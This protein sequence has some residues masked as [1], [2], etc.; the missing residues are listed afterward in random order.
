MDKTQVRNVIIIISALTIFFIGITAGYYLNNQSGNKAD[1]DGLEVH[2]PGELTSPLLTCDT[3]VN[4]GS[5][6]FSV[7]ESKLRNKIADIISSGRAT[8]IAVYFRHLMDG[9]WF[10][11]NERENYTPA[12]MLKVPVMITIYKQAETNPDILNKKLKYEKVYVEENPHY[13][14]PDKL[15]IG[16]E[17][18]VDDLVSRMVK[19]S[20]NE[21]MYL[22]RA[23]FDPTLFNNLYTDLKMKPPNDQISDDYMT[24]KEYAAFYRILFNASYLN[25]QM[26]TKALKVLSNISFN[27]GIPVGVPKGITVAHKFGERT[28]TDDNSKQLH[29][30]GIV[31]L[32][33][34]PYLICIMTKGK[35]FSTLE[36]VLR[37]ISKSVWD[38]NKSRSDEKK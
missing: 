14:P 37:D 16:K 26:S 29:D 31:Y 6:E 17:Y 2:Q 5:D 23:N 32:P 24:V 10:G 36:T 4:L 34:D 8:D 38:E 9:A 28:Y 18:T 21:A 30:C 25:E 13:P 19:Y 20:D 12:S 1:R 35:D 22:L 27:N 7:F 33:K 3:S 11:V 15:E